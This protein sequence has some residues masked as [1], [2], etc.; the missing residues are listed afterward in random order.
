MNQ[1]VG[2][3]TA[4]VRGCADV[5]LCTRRDSACSECVAICTVGATLLRM[6]RNGVFG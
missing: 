2:L 1:G 6:V 5:E 4:V 3:C